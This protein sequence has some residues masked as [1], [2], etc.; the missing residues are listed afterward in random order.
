[1]N[2]SP[3]LNEDLLR[4]TQAATIIAK[5]LNYNPSVGETPTEIIERALINTPELTPT[6]AKTLQEMLKLVESF[7]IPYDNLLEFVDEESEDDM[8]DSEIDDMIKHIDDWDDIMDV[9]DPSELGIVDDETGEEVQGDLSGEMTESTE[10][11]EV[12][13][14]VERIRARMRFHRTSAKRERKLKVAL[15]KKSSGA[16]INHRARRLAVKTMEARLSKGRD[17]KTL[18][19]AEKERIERIVQ[20]RS[21][22]VGRM[23]LKLTSRVRTIE[24]DRL[25]HHSYTK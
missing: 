22:L 3:I 25:S 6:Q 23:A 14:R 19:V 20:K 12:L 24:R 18:S 15:K 8:S 13:S 4:K 11:N 5:A 16:T 21:K 7:G 1:M 2:K 9:Y 10:L 17:I